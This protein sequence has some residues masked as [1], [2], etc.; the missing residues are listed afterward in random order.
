MKIPKKLF[1]ITVVLLVLFGCGKKAP[2]ETRADKTVSSAELANNTEIGSDLTPVEAPDYTDA[3]VTFVSGDVYRYADGDWIYLDIGDLLSVDDSVKTDA[4]SSCELQFGDR[5][6]VRI[7][8]DTECKLS[9]VFLKPGEAKVGINLLTGT[10]VCKVQKLMGSEKFNVIT[11]SATCG[12][13]GTKFSVKQI[14]GENS[15]LA[16]KEGVVAVLPPEYSKIELSTEGKTNSVLTD[17]MRKIESAVPVVTADEEAVIDP[18]LYKD[19][20]ESVKVLAEASEEITKADESGK[21]IP[22]ETVKLL[23]TAGEKIETHINSKD[24]ELAEISEKSKEVLEKTESMKLLDI[25]V[26]ENVSESRT[27]VPK[28]R[29]ISIKAN[30]SNTVIILNGNQVAVGKFSGI[31]K[32]GDVLDFVFENNGYESTDLKISVSSDTK[33]EFSVELKKKDEP[34][35]KKESLSSAEEKTAK[36]DA[37]KKEPSSETVRNAENVSDAKVSEPV[38]KEE[39]VFQINVIVNPPD[40][41]IIINGKPSGKGKFS[42]A[43]PAG[44]ILSIAGKRRGF[45]EKTT[46]VTVGSDSPVNISLDLEPKPVDALVSV[47]KYRISNSVAAGAGLLVV[48][49]V[50]GTVF[51]VDTGG[52][53]LWKIS[54][55]NTSAENSHPVLTGN[56]VFYS[57]P[58]ELIIADVSTG[59]IIKRQDLDANAAH[60]FGRKVI[61]IGENEIFPANN[62][63]EIIDRDT[64]NII[65]KIDIPGGGSRMTPGVWMDKI[66]IVSPDG[67]LRIL[68]SSDGSVEAEIPTGGIQPIAL[69][70]AVKNNLA[71]FSGRK[72]NVVCIDLDNRRVLWENRLSGEK[73][74]VYSDIVLSDKGAYLYSKGTVYGLSLGNG[75]YLFNPVSD[76]SAPPAL[77]GDSLVFGSINSSLIFLDPLTGT[78]QR[79]LTL[80][81]TVSTRPAEFRGRIAVG[82]A[83]GDIVIIDPEGIR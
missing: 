75:K 5:A 43:Y 9:T 79:S 24:I 59:K 81:E 69:S 50:K 1:V 14:E 39:K 71:V 18:S 48:S 64:G 83:G 52:K 34:S 62:V 19:V 6:V 47:S 28:V 53:L 51:A 40:A 21:E 20:A 46:K 38:Q 61:P 30:P 63:L 74:Q 45:S 27:P 23:E 31:F 29:K 77:V 78:K 55:K 41:D 12:V 16:V 32:D 80:D 3:L 57:G 72:G 67:V 35:V 2:Q 13:R 73:V 54:T 68:N 22:E 7:E 49:D 8:G 33:R 44:T 36:G 25:P 70:V 4:D 42:A 60:I 15:V 56:R 58:K 26:V 10:V 65:R 37:D 66:L 11:K 17:T 76:A 82:T